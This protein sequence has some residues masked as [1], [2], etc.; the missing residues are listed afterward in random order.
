MLEDSAKNASANNEKYNKLMPLE[1][2]FSTIS[3]K[4][5]HFSDKK[6]NLYIWPAKWQLFCHRLNVVN[7]HMRNLFYVCAMPS[8]EAGS[9]VFCGLFY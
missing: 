3:T 8:Q 7:M 1:T 6:I 5:R 4:M 2:K 9:V